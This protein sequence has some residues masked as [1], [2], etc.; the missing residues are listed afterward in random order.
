MYFLPFKENDIARETALS[1]LL[2]AI[3]IDF[4]KDGELERRIDNYFNLAPHLK[5]VFKPGYPVKVGNRK[6]PLRIGKVSEKKLEEILENMM[7]KWI[8]SVDESQ[9]NNKAV[10]HQSVFFRGSL[11]YGIKIGT[12]KEKILAVLSSFKISEDFE[13]IKQSVELKTYIQNLLVA[14]YAVSILLAQ[15]E[16]IYSVII[17]GPLIKMLAPFLFTTFPKE[18]MEELFAIDKDLRD[19][20]PSITEFLIPTWEKE[21]FKSEILKE[22]F[23][24]FDIAEGKL[25]ELIKNST[26]YREILEEIAEKEFFAKEVKP[27][28]EAVVRESNGR[29][30][31]GK[32]YPG[33]VLYFFLIRILVDLGKEFGFSVI[34]CV[35]SSEKSTELLRLYYLRALARYL[36]E[37]TNSKLY[38]IIIGMMGNKL[39]PE[40]ALR[41]QKLKELFLK[42]GL[43]DDFIMTFSLEFD[44]NS[45][46]Y[47]TP[48]EIRRHRGRKAN[49]EEVFEVEGERYKVR[50]EQFG[51]ANKE[52]EEWL[53]KILLKKILPPSSYRFLMS[54]VRTTE[55]KFPLRIEFP[56]YLE[57]RIEEVIGSVY[58][59]SIPY[60]NYGIPIVLKY[61]DELVRIPTKTIQTLSKGLITERM[62]SILRNKEM[63]TIPLHQIIHNLLGFLKRDFYS[64]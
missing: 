21:E 56:S 15:G 42:Y 7:E 9:H 55:M 35:K 29:Y 45:A 31:A 41:K 64:R 19:N 48:V 54:Y 1:N 8:I 40:V 50:N 10:M 52:Q 22:P 59:L 57:D 26:V 30:Y 34:S 13:Y 3:L 5:E 36:N 28:K 12:D 16:R 58:L 61:V 38:K 39:D 18:E 6:Y 23:T 53:E 2:S 33:L 20:L 49:E 60:R 44:E 25:L 43:T 63:D 24:V 27:F 32:H 17:D 11:A 47:L 46:N 37:N 51:S 62:F 4:E 14:I